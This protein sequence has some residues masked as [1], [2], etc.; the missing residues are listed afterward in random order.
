MSK[1]KM[2]KKEIS[3]SVIKSILDKGL[4]DSTWRECYPVAY[5]AL[6]DYR[7]DLELSVKEVLQR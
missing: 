3:E 1:K 5:T 7:K 6:L 2:S 4:A